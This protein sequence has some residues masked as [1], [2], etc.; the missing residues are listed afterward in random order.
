LAIDLE[1]P[2]LTFSQSAVQFTRV[3]VLDPDWTVAENTSM[4][5]V[6]IYSPFSFRTHL[7][8][9]VFAVLLQLNSFHPS[10]L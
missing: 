4:R 9:L 5:W 1:L 8:F 10:A 3:L 7:A 2:Y 6:S